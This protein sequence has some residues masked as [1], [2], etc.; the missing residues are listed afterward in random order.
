MVPIIYIAASWSSRERMRGVRDFLQ[1]DY[2]YKVQARW[3]DQSGQ[4]LDK[5]LIN[6]NPE[7][8][9]EYAMIDV[10]DIMSSNSVLLFTDEPS[11]T[12]GR[13]VELGLAI[14]FGK[15]VLVVGPLENIFQTVLGITHLPDFQAFTD[16]VR[17]INAA[18]E[19]HPATNSKAEQGISSGS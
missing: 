17:R 2:G 18:K 10:S 6:N 14:A 3:L 16:H 4:G 12:G 13:H 11:T 7:L 19:R 5:D 9:A 8:A 1:N 15:H